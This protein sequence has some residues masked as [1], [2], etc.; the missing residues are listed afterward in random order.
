MS[1]QCI[2]TKQEDC[3]RKYGEMSQSSKGDKLIAMVVH[4]ARHVKKDK[5][6]LMTV[7]AICL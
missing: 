7:K 3:I 6:I 4:K 5:Y 1:S 2:N